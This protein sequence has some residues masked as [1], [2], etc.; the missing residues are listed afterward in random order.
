MLNGTVF[1]VFHTFVLD[2][3]RNSLT[4]LSVCNWRIEITGERQAGQFPGEGGGWAAEIW[5]ATIY[6]I[7]G[8]HFSPPPP[9]LA[10]RFNRQGSWYYT[11]MA[12]EDRRSTNSH[13][14]DEHGQLIFLLLECHLAKRL[15]RW[16]H[17]QQTD[18]YRY[19]FIYLDHDYEE[20]SS[21][22]KSLLV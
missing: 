11:Y 22:G 2:K 3:Q 14:P 17:A 19:I 18:R 1:F 20:Q 6:L 16:P 21:G 8:I 4:G 13:S 9:P 5:D 7:P 12:N 15:C 10:R